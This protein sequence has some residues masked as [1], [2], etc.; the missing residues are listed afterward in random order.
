ML[1]EIL[2]LLS[3]EGKNKQAYK[4]NIWMEAPGVDPRHPDTYSDTPAQARDPMYRKY[5]R[6]RGIKDR[7]G[8][9]ESKINEG[10]RPVPGEWADVERGGARR[11]TLGMTPGL[12]KT[13]AP[14]SPFYSPQQML[15]RQQRAQAAKDRQLMGGA[16][17]T[18][19]E[20]RELRRLEA[21]G[22]TFRTGYP[23]APQVPKG[24]RGLMDLI[25]EYLG[26]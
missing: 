22:G 1:D 3:G 25:N 16:P 4:D 11:G 12:V 7:I 10:L 6:M 15:A 8:R 17:L 13:G 9:L 19:D 24:E 18:G 21:Q 23:N 14:T 20:I 26:R 2:A 5:S